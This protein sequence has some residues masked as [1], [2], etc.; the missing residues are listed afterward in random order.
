MTV[1]D[2]LQTKAYLK[3]IV[4]EARIVDDIDNLANRRVRP[5]GDL[6]EVQFELALSQLEKIVK[7]RLERL[8][9]DCPAEDLFR[10]KQVKNTLRDIFGP[11]NSL[12][13]YLDQL[14]PLSELTHK[15]RINATG[16]GGV[17]RDNANLEMRNIHATHYGRIC[18]IE[19]PEGK[20]AGLVNTL[21]TYGRVTKDGYIE[22]PY[23]RVLEVKFKNALVPYI[24]QHHRSKH[25]GYEL[26]RQI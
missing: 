14:N 7:Y 10:S 21:T 13:Q 20:N 4:D 9:S 15:R 23:Y 18:P 16:P 24:L 11:V 5:V 26:H 17:S 22:T 12:A 1:A 19:T 8:G 25:M 2:L 3:E 6:L